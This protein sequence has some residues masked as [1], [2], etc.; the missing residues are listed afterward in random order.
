MKKR[1]TF[2]IG[3]LL[4]VCSFAVTTYQLNSSGSGNDYEINTPTPDNNLAI[5]TPTPAPT[6][7]PEPITTDPPFY[8]TATPDVEITYDDIFADAELGM[9]PDLVYSPIDLSLFPNISL[10]STDESVLTVDENG[11][12]KGIAVGETT[13]SA[14]SSTGDVIDEIKVIVYPYKLYDNGVGYSIGYYFGKDENLTIPS[15]IA[16]KPITIIT[17]AVFHFSTHSKSLHGNTIFLLSPQQQRD[18]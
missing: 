7:T 5:G 17:R 8:P 11:Q 4:V 3:I 13:V 6:H 9:V 15:H 10:V 1:I 16:G 18:M 14:V 12:I 2:I